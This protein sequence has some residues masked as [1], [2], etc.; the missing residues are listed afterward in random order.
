MA[1]ASRW[2]ASATSCRLS[3]EDSARS[4]CARA[5][6]M[7]LSSSSTSACTGLAARR[8]TWALPSGENSSSSSPGCARAISCATKSTRVCG[9]SPLEVFTWPICASASM[10]KPSARPRGVPPLRK[11][12]TAST[13]P[14]R[15][16]MP[17]QDTIRRQPSRRHVWAS[18]SLRTFSWKE[19]SKSQTCK[20]NSIWGTAI[21]ASTNSSAWSQALDSSRVYSRSASRSFLASSAEGRFCCRSATWSCNSLEVSTPRSA[22]HVSRVPGSRA[23][24]TWTWRRR[25]WSSTWILPTRW[26]SAAGLSAA[27]GRKGLQPGSPWSA[28]RS[29]SWPV[30]MLAASSWILSQIVCWSPSCSRKEL[31]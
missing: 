22:S 9:P 7:P 28:K 27:S 14:R 13:R 23:S 24:I 3:S 18:E 4:I 17:A 12:P 29:S 15:R 25:S 8:S 6:R 20:R 5:V 1:S 19:L 16:R 21:K 31:Q 10:E 2:G 30:S 26:H 11:L